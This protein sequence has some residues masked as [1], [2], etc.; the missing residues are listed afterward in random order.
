[1]LGLLIIVMPLAILAWVIG[2]GEWSEWFQKFTQYAL[3]APISSLFIYLAVATASEFGAMQISAQQAGAAPGLS[4]ITD[5]IGSMIMIIA[6]LMFGLGLAEKASGAGGKMAV[7]KAE[8]AIKG[9]AKGTL[10][11]G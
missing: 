1:M 2:R 3:F 6:I 10:S 8:G 9:V 5:N 11:G 7:K 4:S